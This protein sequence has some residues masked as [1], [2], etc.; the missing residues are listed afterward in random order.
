MERKYRSL[1]IV[2]IVKNEEK[3][4][5]RCLNSVLPIADDIVVVDSYSTDKTEEICRKY[6]VNFIMH[7]WEGYAGTKNYA[8]L[9]AKYDW[10]LSLDADEVL[11]KELQESIIN[12]KLSQKFD[13]YRIKRR[14]NYCGKWIKFTDW[15]PDIKIRLFNR[16]K[17][18]WIGNHVHEKLVIEDYSGKMPLLE[19]H[20]YHY[21]INS[22]EA[23]IAQVNKFSSL[24]ALDLYEKDKRPTY[25]KLIFS[26]LMI[27]IKSYIIKGG[28]RDGIYGLA[29][30]IIS[31]HARFLRILKLFELRKG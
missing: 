5:D 6:N 28:F 18:K 4:I 17:S 12:A 9:Q 14:T 31:S 2:I 16:Q 23:H 7:E 22:I 27:F 30:S 10:I 3:N 1:S 21:S 8:N 25:G 20:C 15:N 11:S 26:P 24:S 13:F 19:G 29:I